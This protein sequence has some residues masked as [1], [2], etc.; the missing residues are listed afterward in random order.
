MC[1]DQSWLCELPESRAA[2]RS[3]AGN[4]RTRAEAIER[5]LTVARTVGYSRRK[6]KNRAQSIGLTGHPFRQHTL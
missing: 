3:L 6:A 4:Y 2:F 5:S 1:L